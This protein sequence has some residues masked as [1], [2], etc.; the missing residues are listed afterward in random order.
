MGGQVASALAA[1]HAAGI[2][3]RDVTPGN[4]LISED[5][6]A[7][8]TDFGIS[9]TFGD[10]TLTATGIVT[11]TPAFLAPEVAR[12]APSD[13]A[14]D[15]Y[16]LG[17]TLYMAVEGQPP[18]GDQRDN[19]IAVLHRVASGHPRP[20]ARAGVLA[21]ILWAMM[22]PEP[23][24][25]PRMTAVTGQLRALA[26]RS[27]G[28]EIATKVITR[29][30]RPIVVPPVLG[31][32]RTR[33]LAAPGP[34]VPPPIA[35]PPPEPAGSEFPGRSR[36]YAAWIALVVIVALAAVIGILLLR[37]GGTSGGT[38]TAQGPAT[39]S[40]A[41]RTPTKS[42]SHSAAG[43]P[44]R[45]ATS[46]PS[47]PSSAPSTTPSA[48]PSTESVS[49][50]VI[51]SATVSSSAPAQH[52]AAPPT[53][54]EL[55]DAIMQY[56]QL[57]P[58]NLDAAWQRLTRNFQNGRAG[59]RA[60]FDSY[61]NTVQSVDTADV[62]GQSPHTAYATLTYHYK[63]GQVVTERTTFTLVRRGGVLKIA[64]ES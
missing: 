29:E 36:S 12:G 63:N 37:N 40:S 44:A 15:V 39:T 53:D 34:T 42:P 19:P 49:T 54:S 51:S 32:A 13:F 8:I 2:V 9:H 45:H 21:P 24:R 33:A 22:T 41:A 11:G 56:F 6:T 18:F 46:S 52:V 5:G 48:P 1:A 23:E 30:Q 64:A 4:V 27:N 62:T 16:S 10:P 20:P 3:H 26:D 59:G 61:W 38:P 14:S 31:P 28:A 43:A 60:N 7:R 25:R 50:S 17:S 57:V 47:K 35:Q 58:D 55:A